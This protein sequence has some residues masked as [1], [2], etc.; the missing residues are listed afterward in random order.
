MAAELIATKPMPT[1]SVFY[2]PELDSLRFLAFFGVFLFHALPRTPNSYAGIPAAGRSLICGALS[3]G[4]CGVDLFFALSAYLIT[5]LLLR[6]RDA[7]GRLDVGR[8]YVRRILRIWPL[9]FAFILLAA[10]LPLVVKSQVL[11]WRYVAGFVLL[12]GN[13]VYTLHGIPMN[14][15]ALPLWSVSIEEQ[16]YLLWPLVVRGAS[17]RM[18]T[19]LAIALLLL[20][21]I[22][23][24]LLVFRGA[25]QAVLEFHTLTRLDPIA[26]GILLALSER[27]LSTSI[28]VALVYCSV[29]TAVLVGV[30]C[31]LYP[32]DNLSVNE[33]GTVIGRPLMAVASAALLAGIRGIRQTW[34]THPAALYLGKTSYG[35]YV[36]HLLG[37]KIANSIVHPGSLTGSL[38]RASVGLA[39]TIV[40]AALSYRYVEA[41][42]LRVKERF[43]CIRSRPV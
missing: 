42:F 28:R 30:Y 24:M 41:P 19:Q 7:S 12:A 22:T 32:L 10:V 27:E 33:A 34:I 35:L 17:R 31:G 18:M 25:S 20:A 16:F 13:W 38:A 5:S 29:V 4:A 37:L 11:G 40:L 15:I 6:E 39:V 2:R 43:A 21:N 8:F 1:K 36:F 14:S 3:A 23:R 9:Y 26:L